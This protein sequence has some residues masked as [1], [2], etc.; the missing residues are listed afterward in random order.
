VTDVEARNGLQAKILF[1]LV[2][3]E[4]VIAHPDDER[5][6][7]KGADTGRGKGVIPS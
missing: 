6:G 3:G 1:G 2:E 5:G 4:I 7:D